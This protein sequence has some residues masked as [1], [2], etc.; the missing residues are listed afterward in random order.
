[1]VE[2]VVTGAEI[3]VVACPVVV[4]VAASDEVVDEAVVSPG[5][6]AAATRITVRRLLRM[7]PQS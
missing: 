7:S 1:M 2:L 6:Q 4:V 5:L 3:V